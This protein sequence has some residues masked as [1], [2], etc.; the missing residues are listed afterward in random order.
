[1]A[2][3]VQVTDIC[4]SLFGFGRINSGGQ[5]N[6][7]LKSVTASKCPAEIKKKK[8]KALYIIHLLLTRDCILSYCCEVW[9]WFG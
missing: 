5:V 8:K 9:G 4:K 1:M 7:I 2:D 3:N 6:V